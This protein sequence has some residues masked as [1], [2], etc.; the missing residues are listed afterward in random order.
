MSDN[1]ISIGPIGKKFLEQIADGEP[2][3]RDHLEIGLQRVLNE[4]A[5]LRERDRFQH[6]LMNMHLGLMATRKLCMI[7]F[8]NKNGQVEEALVALDREITGRERR[9][10]ENHDL[11]VAEFDRQVDVGDRAVVSNHPQHAALYEKGDEAGEK[12]R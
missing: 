1:R 12:E 7:G 2:V 6:A 11:D 5:V 3:S 8:L 9:E 4:L 10:V